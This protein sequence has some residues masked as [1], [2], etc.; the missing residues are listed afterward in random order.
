MLVRLRCFRWGHLNRPGRH[1]SHLDTSA[2]KLRE[3][4][5][6]RRRQRTQK[7]RRR[8]TMHRP[9]RVW[10]TP[11]RSRLPD[12]CCCSPNTMCQSIELHSYGC[13]RRQA[14][15][16]RQ[17][18]PTD[19]QAQKDRLVFQVHRQ[20]AQLSQCPSILLSCL[21]DPLDPSSPDLCESAPGQAARLNS[22]SCCIDSSSFA[23]AA[24][25]HP[26][27]RGNVIWPP[28]T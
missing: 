6:T 11:R 5:K 23:F 4:R 26:C 19:A 7:L 2:V 21:P 16:H 1:C 12:N 15:K 25:A 18:G 17:S 24:F 13:R 10:T 27:H 28:S 22:A 9:F 8:R 3:R 20:A 14:K